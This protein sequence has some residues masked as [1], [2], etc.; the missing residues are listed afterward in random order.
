MGV[1]VNQ[2]LVLFAFMLI[3]YILCRRG[4]L[5]GGFSPLLSAM[6]VYIF[7][8]S[9]MFRSFASNFTTEY[10]STKW[11]LILISVVLLAVITLI[12][13][14]AGK[15][16][17]RT[18]FEKKVYSYSFAIPNC[19]YMGY[20]LVE[21]LYGQVGLLDMMI[22]VLPI[23]IYASTF[24]YCMLTSGSISLKR[25]VNPPTISVIL[26]CI[27][28]LLRIQMPEILTTVLDQAGACMGP[29][30][31]V[32]TGMVISEFPLIEML[33]DARNYIVSIC[34]LIVVPALVWGMLT[35]VGLEEYLPIAVLCYAMPCGLN[36]I[37]MPRLV[38]QDCKMGAVVTVISSSLCC[39]TIPLCMSLFIK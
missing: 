38:G 33:K 32:L 12:A 15:V 22:F 31:M 39:G 17:G 19:S 11:P 2:V 26:G 13:K 4:V 36:T 25:L 30:S 7:L 1:V 28:G 35:I 29:V 8:P 23:S 10:I 6:L 34:R 9:K 3:G 37:I 16:L 5:K 27:A 20:P 21:A 18:D 24:G 14:F